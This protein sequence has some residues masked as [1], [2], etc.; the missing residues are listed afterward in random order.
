MPW[1]SELFQA[2]F[3]FLAL[4]FALMHQFRLC[5]WGWDCAD[6]KVRLLSLRGYENG[7]NSSG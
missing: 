6:G 1:F 2:I 7:R 3:T 4:Q 5:V